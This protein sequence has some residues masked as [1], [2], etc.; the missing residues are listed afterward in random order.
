M[1]T[2]VPKQI[3]E[4]DTQNANK[5]RK[6]YE[7]FNAS[8]DSINDLLQNKNW[9]LIKNRKLLTK[10]I[11]RRHVNFFAI[12]REQSNHIGRVNLGVSSVAYFENLVGFYL[13]AFLKTRIQNIR[14]DICK[15]LTNKRLRDMG[16]KNVRVKSKGG[17]IPDI[18]IV[19]NKRIKAILEL[20][21]QFGRRRNQPFKSIN[22]KFEIYQ[23]I[24][25]GKEGIFEIIFTLSNYK[26]INNVD[27]FKSRCKVLNDRICIIS[28]SHPLDL[29]NF[30]ETALED[31][32]VDSIE[33][34]F[35]EICKIIY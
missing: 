23:K 3:I 16:Y 18:T 35:D 20:E 4:L 28:R 29:E 21:F 26:P 2:N 34:I 17:P 7:E 14:I 25:G 10:S 31:N 12:E 11:L 24:T 30:S 9:D 6:F 19:K 13:R 33:V 27:D 22:D 15:Q 32:V 1:T 5:R 8:E